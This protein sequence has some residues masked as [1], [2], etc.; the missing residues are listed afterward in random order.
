MKIKICRA[1]GELATKNCPSK[2]EWFIAGTEPKKKDKGKKKEKRN[3]GIPLYLK[4]PT[5]GLQLAMDPRI[6]DELEAFALKLSATEL[7]EADSI[8]WLI[9][10]KVIGRTAVEV[11]EFLWPV[12]RGTHIAQA[13]IWMLQGDE[14][15][16]TERVKFYVK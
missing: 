8:E 11:R 12:K 10:G 14:P 7:E 5:P 3:L 9:D 13:R 16:K 4:Q 6:P 15:L 2:I 1:T